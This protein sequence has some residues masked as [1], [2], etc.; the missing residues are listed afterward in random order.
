MSMLGFFTSCLAA[1]M[2]LVSLLIPSWDLVRN[3]AL[4]PGNPWVAMHAAL[5]MFSYGIFGM[6]ALTSLLYFIRQY[7][8]RYKRLGGWF[9]FFPPLA[10]LEVMSLRLHLAGVG[11]LSIALAVGC[12]HWRAQGVEVSEGKLLAVLLVWAAY[13]LALVLRWRGILVAR[14]YALACTLLFLAAMLSLWP[15]D[16]SRHPLGPSSPHRVLAP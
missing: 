1:V 4:I 2:T 6:L 3:T 10:D 8:L 13:S 11:M 5:A 9:S 7:S 12:V 16:R 15:V 14:R